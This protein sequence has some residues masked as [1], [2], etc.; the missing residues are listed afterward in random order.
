[1]ALSIGVKKG[2]QINIGGERIGGRTIMDMYQRPK[3]IDYTLKGGQTMTVVQVD[4]T[5]KI[6][7]EFCGKTLT[8]TDKERVKLQEGV[9]VSCGLSNGKGQDFYGRLAFEA[10]RSVRIERIHTP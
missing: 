3:L 10:P 9:F 7:V 6:V 1:M 8:L 4:G 2:S 5:E